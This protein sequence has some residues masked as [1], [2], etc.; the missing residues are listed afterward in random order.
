MWV[1]VQKDVVFLTN[2][3]VSQR[4]ICIS[5]RYFNT[6]FFSL[7]PDTIEYRIITRVHLLQGKIENFL[8]N[9]DYEITTQSQGEP[10]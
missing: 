1:H 3:N 2:F 10:T 9:L 4:M 5:S 7:A 8:H 6:Y